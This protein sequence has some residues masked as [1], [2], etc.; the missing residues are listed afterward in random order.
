[1]RFT[2]RFSRRKFLQQTA[3]TAAALSTIPVLS[4]TGV[5][6]A[7]TSPDGPLKSIPITH[8]LAKWVVQSHMSD[9]PDSVRK[10]AVR[11]IVNSV[12]AT[13]GGS[14]DETVTTAMRVLRPYSGPPKASLFG[15]ADRLDPLNAALVNGISS[16]VLDYDDTELNT[17]IHPAGVVA[18]ALFALAADHPVSGTE[19]LHAFILG[20]EIECRLGDAIYPS[21]YDLGWHITATCGVFGAAAACGKLLGLDEQKMVWALSTAAV[22]ASGL[23]VVFGSMGKSFQ[24]G[25]AAENGLLSALLAQEGFT[26]SNMPLEGVGGYLGAASRHYDATRLIDHLGD[27]Y[28]ITSNTY[29]PFP[30][31]IVIHPAIDAAIQMKKQF[32]LR[33]EEMTYIAIRANP[34]M[35][36]LTGKQTP[37]TGLEGKFSA[38]HSVAI[39]LIRGQVGL[40]EYTDASVRN[41]EVVALRSKVH[42][43][44]DPSI[45]SD[46]VYMSITTADGHVYEKHVEHAIGSLQRPMTDT[47][48]EVKFLGLAHP[49]LPEQQAKS[50][51]AMCW[52]VESLANVVEIPKAGALRH[53]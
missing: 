53:A 12:G 20:T 23:K 22:Q 48:L 26:G 21:H 52:K 17:I 50:L 18:S 51:L 33:P 37:R 1:M 15:R 30:C 19:F 3:S 5:A 11:S 16:H 35:L 49:V 13:V 44:T 42:I 8:T 27:H 38:Y 31:G 29:K 39:A 24:V 36:Q 7:Q 2:S 32:H 25:R 47:D 28:E 14:A 46:E 4:A 10:E 9:I 43:T 6:S 34:L 40:A 45:R 41:S